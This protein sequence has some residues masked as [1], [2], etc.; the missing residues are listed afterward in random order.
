MI[1][2][3]LKLSKYWINNF[4]SLLSQVASFFIQDNK[5]LALGTTVFT[6]TKSIMLL[7]LRYNV[8]ET[9]LEET[10]EPIL[11]NLNSH[12]MQFYAEGK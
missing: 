5:L 11:D 10:I 6:E 9:L 1:I 12:H 4:I 2:S 3:I 8:L 7:D